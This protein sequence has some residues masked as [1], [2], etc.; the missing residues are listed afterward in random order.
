MR[1]KRFK[2]VYYELVVVAA[3]KKTDIWLA[4]DGG[5]LVQKEV[6]T[7]RTRILPGFYTVE[8]GLGN[9]TY[10]ILLTKPSRYTQA[11]LIELGPCP[12]PKIRLLPEYESGWATEVERRI[13]KIESALTK[14]VP[15]GKA[16]S[17]ARASIRRIG[18]SRRR[19]DSN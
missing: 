18:R 3:S 7:L 14:L 4:D 8:F 12:R 11:E 15:A 16:I 17:R 10:P 13:K 2:P 6:G 9:P 19:L 5:H 1:H